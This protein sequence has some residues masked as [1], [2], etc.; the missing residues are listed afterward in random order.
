MTKLVQNH[1]KLQSEYSA[2]LREYELLKQKANESD[3]G[4]SRINEEFQ[5]L[6]SIIEKLRIERTSI[7]EKVNY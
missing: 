1:G 2:L 4:V 5:R 6:Q 3:I 7:I